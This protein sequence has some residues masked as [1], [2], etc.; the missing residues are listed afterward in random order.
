MT[1]DADAN[2]DTVITTMDT[3]ASPDAPVNMSIEG[4]ITSISGETIT[5]S[6]MSVTLDA[7]S[8]VLKNAKV[9]DCL[10]VEGSINMDKDGKPSVTPASIRRVDGKGISGQGSN[11]NSN[12]N[13]I[14]GG[15][16]DMGDMGNANGN[17]NMGNGNG[18][19]GGNGNS[20]GGGNGGM[21]H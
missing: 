16:A 3:V 6:D 8:S 2:L 12:G 21:G 4:C 9:G 5:I 19:S 20:N 7:N 11:G 1:D 14:P 13:G 15:N 18:N 17:G 10:H